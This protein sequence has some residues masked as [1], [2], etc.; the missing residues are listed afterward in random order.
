M[1]ERVRRVI[2]VDLVAL[3]DRPETQR[4]VTAGDAVVE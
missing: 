1:S 3:D 4:T 2:E